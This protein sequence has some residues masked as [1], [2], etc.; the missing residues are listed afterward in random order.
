MATLKK[1]NYKTVVRIFRLLWQ[2]FLSPP[3]CQASALTWQ[4]DKH[5]SHFNSVSNL[6]NRNHLIILFAIWKIKFAIFIISFGCVIRYICA[7]TIKYTKHFL[8]LEGTICLV[9]ID[10]SMLKAYIE[11][12]F[13][14]QK[15]FN[16]WVDTPL[17]IVN[18]SVP[19]Y[20][21]TLCI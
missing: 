17:F 16:M 1:T 13:C 5:K 12:F 10:S 11:I 6:I 20:A 14:S 15:Y 18:R 9:I 2:C 8:C 21:S 4:A 7:L 19:L 3:P